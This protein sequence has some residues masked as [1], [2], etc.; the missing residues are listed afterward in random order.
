MVRG[1]PGDDA[2]TACGAGWGAPSSAR[3][4]CGT[5]R[6][7]T[8]GSGAGGERTRDCP[9]RLPAPAPADTVETMDVVDLIRAWRHKEKPASDTF[10]YRKRMVAAAPVI[11]AKPSAGVI[12][13]VAGNAAFYLGDPATTHIS[14]GVG[15]VT[16]TSKGQA[17]INA[18][19]TV[20]GRDNRW[21]LEGDYRFQWTSQETFG[22]GTDT[23]APDGEVVRFDFYRLSQSAQY[24][25]RPTAVRRRR[26]AL[27]QPHRCRARRRERR[28]LARLRVLPV[29]RRQ[30][31]AA[32]DSAV[33]RSERGT[34]LGQPRQLH[35]SGSRLAGPR[36]LSR[37]VRG[38]SRRRFG[39]AAGD[40]RRPRLP[41]ADLR[42]PPQAGDVGVCRP[43]DR[44]ASR[45]TSICPR[46]RA[47]RTAARD[48]AMP[49]GTSAARSWRSRRSSIGAR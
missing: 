28:H 18:H 20:F 33:G 25:L 11:G 13:G 34:H 5:S 44:R 23:A 38:V 41:R 19:N 17:G 14:S 1:R 48:A 42:S 4:W 43:G 7:R 15:S 16:F 32:R 49:K 2:A 31:S 40:A 10:D 29:Q 30:R 39:L 8:A 12:I 24:R 22:L 35:Q 6:G 37:D 47:T 9:R 26:P 46:R 3:G 27:R 36:R 45:P 21:R